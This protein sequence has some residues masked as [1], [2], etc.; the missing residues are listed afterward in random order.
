MNTSGQRPNQLMPKPDYLAPDN[1]VND[2]II[3]SGMKFTP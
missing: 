2:D 3:M 1:L